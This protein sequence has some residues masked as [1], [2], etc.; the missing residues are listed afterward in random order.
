VHFERD[1]HQDF[2]ELWGSIPERFENV[3]VL[4][5]VRYDNLDVANPPALHSVVHFD[6]LYLGT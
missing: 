5:E 2:V 1:L 6:D 3:R 4:F